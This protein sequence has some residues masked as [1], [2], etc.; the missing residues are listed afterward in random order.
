MKVF[1][2]SL[3]SLS[4][5]VGLSM[6][7][8]SPIVYS[9]NFPILV[10]PKKQYV[11]W[12]DK[13]IEGVKSFEKFEPAPYRCPA[14]VLTVGYGHTGKYASKHMNKQQAEK[15]LLEELN[16]HRKIVLRNVKVPITEYQLC[17][18]TSFCFNTGEGNLRK[19][20][21]GKN[22]LNSGNYDSVAKLMPMYRKGGGKVLKGLVKRRTW[23]VSLWKGTIDMRS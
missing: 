20:I 9:K 5:L 23:E 11:I 3:L 1:M 12:E 2:L 22:R 17:A 14:G 21:N 16:K 8:V 10:K 7:S 18:L 15:L 4:L 13:M 6:Q 19:L